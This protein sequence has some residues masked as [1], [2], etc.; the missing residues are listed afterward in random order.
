MTLGNDDTCKV[1]GNGSVVI[2]IHDGMMRTLS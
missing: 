1:V 2:K